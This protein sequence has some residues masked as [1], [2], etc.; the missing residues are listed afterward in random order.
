MKPIQFVCEATVPHSPQVIAEQML[1]MNRWPEF[2]GYG[3][4]P[5]IRSAVFEER[6][7]E[8]RGSRIRV[9]STDDSQHIETI[10][11]WNLPHRIQLEFSDFRP[12]LA[13]LATRFV[14]IW[15]FTEG[16]GGTHVKRRFEL[17]PH[18]LLTRFPLWL[19]S[20]LLRGAARQHLKLIQAAGNQT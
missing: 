10:S 2:T 6:T 1:D 17:Y 11:E 19:I 20:R 7:P 3:P 8:V 9:T 14:E 18:S 15:D 12:P 16:P 4:M 13:L 5:G